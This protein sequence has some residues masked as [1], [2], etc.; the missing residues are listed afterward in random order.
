[1]GPPRGH[2]SCQQ[3]CSS[4]VSSLHGSTGPARNLLQRGLPTG[5]QR[6]WGIPLLRCGVLH[7]LQVDICSTVNLHGLQGDSLPHHGLPHGL[8]GNLCSGAWSTSS[9]SF[10]TDLGVC[11][12]VSLT[13]SHSS[14]QLQ[15]VVQFF[16]P[17][18]ICYPRGATTIADGLGLDQQRV[19]LGASWHWLYQTQGKLLGASHRSHPCS[20]PAT[21]TL[22]CKPNTSC[23][24]CCFRLILQYGVE[25]SDIKSRSRMV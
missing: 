1:M 5:S 12:V 7:G 8:Q 18:L 9:P 19:H 3:T 22:P 6:P 20:P 11:R 10:F 17:S 24:R 25:G 14:L 23:Y 2:K 16:S 13:Y 21:K 4:V 15:F